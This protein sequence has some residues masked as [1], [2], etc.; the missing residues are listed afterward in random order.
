M[1]LLIFFY[2]VYGFIDLF[3]AIDILKK[4]ED[5][6]GIDLLTLSIILLLL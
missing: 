3:I 5:H 4:I 1:A 2:K 6:L